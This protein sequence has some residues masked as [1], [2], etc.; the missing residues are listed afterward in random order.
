M[1]Q[2]PNFRHFYSAHDRATGRGVGISQSEM[3]TPASRG[4]AR[5][6]EAQGSRIVPGLQNLGVQV[7]DAQ[8][9][10]VTAE[11][12]ADRLAE[13]VGPGPPWIARFDVHIVYP[14]PRPNPVTQSGGEPSPD[15]AG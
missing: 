8:I 4:D 10:E 6:D 2:T 1:R 5:R 13:A 7:E 15:F 11:A 12:W 9:L 3:P 14:R